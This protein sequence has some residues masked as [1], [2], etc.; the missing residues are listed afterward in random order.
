MQLVRLFIPL[1]NKFDLRPR[2]HH[3][4]ASTM[5]HSK[6][7]LVRTLQ[8]IM[9]LLVSAPHCDVFAGR[10]VAVYDGDECLSFCEKMNE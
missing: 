8:S 2:S 7:P 6:S 1:V 4:L 3:L 5:S 9:E 10:W